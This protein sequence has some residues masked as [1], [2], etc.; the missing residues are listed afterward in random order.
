MT[1]IYLVSGIITLGAFI[2]LLAALLKGEKLL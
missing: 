2:Y 1:I